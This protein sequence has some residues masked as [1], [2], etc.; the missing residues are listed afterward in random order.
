MTKAIQAIVGMIISFAFA[1]GQQPPVPPKP[2]RTGTVTDASAAVIP[3]AKVSL[4]RGADSVPLAVTTTDHSGTFEFSSGEKGIFKVVAESK[5][6][7][8]TVVAA[9][10]GKLDQST[11]LPPITLQLAEVCPGVTGLMVTPVIPLTPEPS[12]ISKSQQPS[13]TVKIVT[14]CE[15]LENVKQYNNTVVA[16]AGRLDEPGE[17]LI[18]HYEFLAQDHCKYPIAT[19]DSSGPARFSSLS[20]RK[21]NCQGH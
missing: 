9:V 15:L 5:C 13:K 2:T 3:R 17:S 12:E 16:V 10:A 8:P 20:K 4:F 7:D 21:K 19:K 14:V 11:Q 1:F 18:D 6:F